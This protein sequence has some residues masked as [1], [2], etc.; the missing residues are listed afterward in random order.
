MPTL[1]GEAL[2]SAPPVAVGACAQPTAS[3]SSA[4]ASAELQRVRAHHGNEGIVIAN[5]P[6]E[7]GIQHPAIHAVNRAARRQRAQ[8]APRMARMRT[9]GSPLVYGD[10]L[11]RS[12]RGV[13]CAPPTNRPH[14]Q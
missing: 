4:A 10:H 2:G 9:H 5:P 1:S 6:E 7:G 3:A 12:V 8:A 14:R 13:P 11:A